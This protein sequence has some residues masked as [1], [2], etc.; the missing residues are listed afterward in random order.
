MKDTLQPGSPRR[1]FIV[2]DHPMMRLGLSHFLT[3]DGDISICGEAADA[4]AALAGIERVHPDPVLLDISLEGRSGLDLLR[5]L[6]LRFPRLAVLVD[7]MH[8]ELIYAERALAAGARGYLMKQEGGEKLRMAV[9]QVPSGRI[10]LSGRLQASGPARGGRTSRQLAPTPI[11]S[12]SQRELEVFR[13]V[14]RGGATT[15]LPGSFI[16]ASK[17][18]KRTASTSSAS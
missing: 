18:S 6:R 8:D 15:T 2:D 7:P 9:R 4:G 3:Q 10:Y 14:G 12:L 11:G 1:V 17:P 5:D 16:L 13:L